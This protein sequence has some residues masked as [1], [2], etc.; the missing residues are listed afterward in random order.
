MD[1]NSWEDLEEVP[2]RLKWSRIRWQKSLG[3]AANAEAAAESVGIKPVTYRAYERR[4]DG[5]KSIELGVS[6]IIRLAK[7]FGVSWVWLASGEGSPFD[8]PVTGP[9]A[10]VADAMR[11]A[12]PDRQKLAADLAL[13]VLINDRKDGTNN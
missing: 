5:S 1:D 4:S 6:T 9:A 11:R 8:Q 3:L 12:D 7:K 2:D 13:R 10:Q